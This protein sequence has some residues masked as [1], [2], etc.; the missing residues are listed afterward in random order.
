[1][2]NNI[3]PLKPG[4]L[5]T[6][7][8]GELASIEASLTAWETQYRVLMTLPQVTAAISIL[9]AALTPCDPRQLAVM[10]DQTLQL[11]PSPDNF[12]TTGLF[13]VEALEDV[14]ADIV[15]AALKH[16]RL[17]HRY[18]RMPT[19]AD[20]RAAAAGALVKRKV[21]LSKAQ[22]AQGN[23]IREERLKAERARRMASPAPAAP[24][25]KMK[26]KPEW[27]DPSDGKREIDLGNTDER[28]AD[29]RRRAANMGIK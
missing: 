25:P 24:L 19:P 3:T 1:M 18:Q 8:A 26:P 15:E 6:Q 4:T 16:V 14:P 23:L 27:R 11:W 10:L 29:W 7:A 20:F 22:L 12:E 17:H 28:L 2:G 5:T 21:A 9:E 13:Y